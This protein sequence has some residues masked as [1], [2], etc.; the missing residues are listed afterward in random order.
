MFKHVA[1][2]ATLKIKMDAGEAEV[3]ALVKL[4]D[5]FPITFK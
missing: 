5:I 3:V 4:K 2:I 1:I